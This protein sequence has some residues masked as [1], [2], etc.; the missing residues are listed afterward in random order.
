MN[1]KPPSNRKFGFLFAVIFFLLSIHSWSNDS[2]GLTS[3]TLLGACFAFAI[4]ALLAPILLTPFNAGWM[5]LGDIMGKIISPLVLSIIF[6]FLITPIALLTRLFG[7]DELRLRRVNSST[8][9]IKRTPPGPS[10][11]TF[12]DQ[13]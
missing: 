13:Y 8:Y 12:K 10:G 11:D 7:R 4:A 2:V 5:K 1:N 3:Y 9:W 6:F